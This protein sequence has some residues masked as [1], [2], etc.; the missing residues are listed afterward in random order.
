[1]RLKYVTLQAK[2][3]FHAPLSLLL[4]GAV[5]LHEENFVDILP[6]AWELLLEPSQEVAAAAAALF[7]LA[8]VKAPT[9]ASNVMQHGLQHIETSTRIEAVLR[10]RL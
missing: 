6:V 1:L 5:I 8:A 9:Q 7:I 4:K 3:L 2:S 10:Y